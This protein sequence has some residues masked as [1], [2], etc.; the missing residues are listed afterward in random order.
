LKKQGPREAKKTAVN[1]GKSK[2]PKK[3]ATGKISERGKFHPNDREGGE[4]RMGGPPSEKN[5]NNVG[6]K[7]KNSP[8]KKGGCVGGGGGGN[9]LGVLGWG[10]GGTT[11]PKKTKSP[12]GKTGETKRWGTPNERNF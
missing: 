1:G 10:G 5:G 12:P 4:I 8:S 11:E 6:Q 9:P 7:K 3:K 2:C